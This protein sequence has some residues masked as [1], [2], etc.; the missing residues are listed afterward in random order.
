MAAVVLMARETAESRGL[1][2]MARMV[3]YAFAGVDP[4]YMGIG[5]VPAIRNVLEKTQGRQAK[6][7]GRDI[8]PDQG[9]D[10]DQARQHQQHVDLQFTTAEIQA[11]ALLRPGHEQQR[12]K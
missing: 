6:V 11:A 1:K 2:P 3:D 7:F 8:E 12:G 5:P 4:K 9:Q 10:G